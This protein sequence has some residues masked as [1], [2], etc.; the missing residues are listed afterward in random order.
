MW[1]CVKCCNKTDKGT[2]VKFVG[3]CCD[4][5]IPEEELKYGP[6]HRCKLCN[7]R[8]LC[9]YDERTRAQLRE[10]TVCFSCNHF[11]NLIPI[12]DEPTTVR[13]GGWHY[14]IEPEPGPNENRSFLGHGGS[15]FRIQFNDGRYVVSR[16]LWCQGNIPSHLREQLPDNATFLPITLEWMAEQK[17]ERQQ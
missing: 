10:R 12:K 7:K 15:P 8:E 1:T 14:M 9:S 13:V 11:L 2:H 4:E 3:F 16:N 5:C 17:K 6:S